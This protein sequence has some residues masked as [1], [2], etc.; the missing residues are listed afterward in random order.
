[1]FSTIAINKNLPLI[2]PNPTDGILNVGYI[3][4]EGSATINIYNLNG[5]TLK[6]F[7][8]QKEF[9]FNAFDVSDLSKGVYLIG[10]GKGQTIKFIVK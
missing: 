7:K 5:T 10:F 1:M 8:A 2:F 6:S 4:L 3:N 9:G